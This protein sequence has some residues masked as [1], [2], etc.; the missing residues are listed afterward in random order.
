MG[1]IFGGLGLVI[2]IIV[3]IV[4]YSGLFIVNQTQ[5]ALVLRF[6]NPVR[7]ATEPGIYAKIPLIDNVVMLDKRLLDIDSPPIEVIARDRKRLVMD[8]FGRYKIVDPLLFYQ[9][10]GSVQVAESRLAVI[11]NSAIRGAAGQMDFSSIVREG[12]ARLMQQITEQVQ[13]E[14]KRLG[15]DV[16]DVRI[17]RADLPP[18]NSQAVYQRMQTERQREATEI[19]AQGEQAARTIRAQA[20]RQATVIVAEANQRA[21]EIK[22]DG[23][24]QRNRIFATAFEQDPD[25]FSFYRSMQAYQDGMKS[26]TTRMVISPSSPFFRYLTDPSGNALAVPER[27]TPGTPAPPKAATPAPPKAVTPAPAATEPAPAAT[28]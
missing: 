4:A 5:Q 1:R 9:A 24:A 28:P 11:L 15:V 19:R 26:D 20:D 13:R 14:G 3:A 10:A 2:V 8:A 22:G 25:F 18:E 16:V 12:R 17:R 21:D 27:A 23:D 7:V 6:G